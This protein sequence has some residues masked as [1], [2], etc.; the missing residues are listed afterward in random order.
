M[1]KKKKKSN[2]VTYDIN[3]YKTNDEYFPYA[4]DIHLDGKL[5]ATSKHSSLSIAKDLAEYACENHKKL[6]KYKYTV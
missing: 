3:L 6:G 1:F 5:I 4:Y 2:P